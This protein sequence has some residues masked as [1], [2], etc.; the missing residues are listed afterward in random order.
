MSFITSTLLDI[1]LSKVLPTGAVGIRG[2]AADVARQVRDDSYDAL[3]KYT[4]VEPYCIVDNTL[5]VQSYTEALY[6]TS[7]YILIG[8]YLQAVSLLNHGGGIPA[9]SMLRKLSPEG[10]LMGI[11]QLQV[12]LNEEKRAL[13]SGLNLTTEDSTS[14]GAG[15]P[16]DGTRNNSTTE[17]DEKKDVANSAA[18]KEISLM[19]VKKSNLIAGQQLT[20]NFNNGK[21]ISPIVVNIKYDIIETPPPL[22]VD[23]LAQGSPD[24]SFNTRLRQLRAGSIR[25]WQ[26]F[27][28]ASD[29]LEEQR[30]LMLMD[31][32]EVIKN[33]V[34]RRGQ[35]LANA[36][37]GSGRN[38]GVSSN[39]LILSSETLLAAE[40]KMKGTLDGERMREA[41]FRTMSLLLLV[42]VDKD[43]E[44]FTF[45][46]RNKSAPTTV[47]AKALK[48]GVGSKEDSLEALAKALAGNRPV[49]L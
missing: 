45:Y 20:V 41:I 47:S 12:R 32:N 16:Y 34:K 28:F 46:F 7:L 23:Y 35:A 17:S 5:V 6:Q 36:V 42:V 8:Y 4:R 48:T 25:F 33:I 2:A 44:R 1:V 24:S 30:K 13:S 38:Y 40:T 3:V 39:C 29:L 18:I 14:R 27:V 22:L 19:E 11:E 15:R 43:Y 37:A 10:G 31:K 26:D 9:I 21:T 49:S